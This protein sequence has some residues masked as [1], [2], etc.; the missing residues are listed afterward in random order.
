MLNNIESFIRD[1]INSFQMARLYGLSHP[2]FIKTAEACFRS[3]QAVFLDRAEFTIGIVGEE[4]AFEKEIFFDLSK[5]LHLLITD[6]KLRGIE[7]IIFKSNVSRQEFIKFISFLIVPKEEISKEP[8]QDLSNLGIYNIVVGKIK[9]T[10]SIDDELKRSLNYIN[11]YKDSLDKSAKSIDNILEG[12]SVDYRD[13][14]SSISNL[15][16][17]MAFQNKEFL[18]LATIKRYD[19][20]TFVHLLNVCILSMYFSSKI[21]FNKEDVV[22]IGVAGLFH[23]V[24]K[25]YISRKIIQKKDKL[26]EEEFKEIESHS[27][28]GAEILLKAKDAL[29]I[30]P[31][32][33]AFEHHIRYDF[34][35]YPKLNFPIKPHIASLIVSICDVYD[36]ICQRRSY[37]RDYPPNEIYHILIKEK[38][39]LFDPRLTDRFFEIFGVWPVGTI[40]S[41]SDSRIAIVREE[42]ETDIFSPKVEIVFPLQNKEIIDLAQ[43]KD[44]YK[45][46]FALNPFSKGKD[47]LHLV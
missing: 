30:L 23:D 14:K 13:L 18:K 35:G 26:T 25:L 20:T 38:G 41:L 2:E 19:I 21:G 4:L 3:L 39:R 5:N 6:L 36:A 17:S 40:V 27:A 45:I 16:T 47:F 32:V 44:K 10:A 43:T 37:K 29:G 31:V 33:V 22:D 11:L 15:M 24:G 46:E 34:S 28:I 7:K 42:N 1:L 12:K 8:E 9:P